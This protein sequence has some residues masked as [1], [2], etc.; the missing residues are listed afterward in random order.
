MQPLSFLL[1]PADCGRS[2]PVVRRPDCDIMEDLHHLRVG[3]HLVFDA[4]RDKFWCRILGKRPFREFKVLF[5]F[6]APQLVK[7]FGA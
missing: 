7:G 2:P 1:F 4:P 5:G 6:T 3:V